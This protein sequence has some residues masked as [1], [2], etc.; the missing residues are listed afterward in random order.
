[1][2]NQLIEL[3]INNA[4]IC[5]TAWALHISINAVVRTLIKNARR[6]NVIKNAR[7]GM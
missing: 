3:A 1:M 7:R 6:G 2:T 4:G 5:D